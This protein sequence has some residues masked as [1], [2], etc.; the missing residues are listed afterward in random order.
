MLKQPKTQKKA[1]LCLRQYLRIYASVN[2]PPA[3]EKKMFYFRINK[4]KIKDNREN[5]QFI[6]FGPDKAEVKLLSFIIR[7]DFTFPDMDELLS[8]NDEARKREIIA[9]GAQQVASSRIL[10]TIENVKDNSIMTFGDTGYVLYQSATIPED[11]NW[12]LIAI[13]SDSDVRNLGQRIEAVINDEVFDDFTSSLLV[14][15]ASAANPSYIA[16]VQIAKFIAKVISDNL[17]KDKDDL[18]GILYMSLNRREHY[19]HLERKR[20]DV[21]DL[22]NNMQIDYSIFGFES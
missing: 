20:D 3:K 21:W 15:L 10:T 12:S 14:L 4:L 18:I 22:T 11:F 19:P 16:G 1:A 13:E 17:K 8:S 6:L 9:A 2:L 7:D 5:P